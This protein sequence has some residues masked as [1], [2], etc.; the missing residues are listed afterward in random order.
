MIS[1]SDLIRFM[2]V[3]RRI[4]R[5]ESKTKKAAQEEVFGKCCSILKNPPS[6]CRVLEGAQY[7]FSN[8]GIGIGSII[9]VVGSCPD[10]LRD[11]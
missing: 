7:L 10:L 5:Y 8:V 2:Y 11:Q 9:G 1:I 3:N 4:K 6:M